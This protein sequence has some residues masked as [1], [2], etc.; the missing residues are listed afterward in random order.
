ML[1]RSGIT[2]SSHRWFE[3][4]ADWL[5]VRS[6]RVVAVG[7]V[8]VVC[9]GFGSIW[10][11][12]HLEPLGFFPKDNLVLRDVQRLQKDLT[13]TDTIEATVDFGRS[14]ELA[15]LPFVERLRYVR[16][17]E[18]K[19]AS[20]PGIVHTMS[21]ATLFPKEMPSGLELTQLLARAQKRQSD[22]DFLAGGDQYWRLSAYIRPDQRGQIG[23]AHV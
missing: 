20:H 21:L 11:R 8:V 12:S 3:P 13:T 16:D 14:L 4:L 10:L 18:H 2:D 15:S 19:I 6:R 17:L 1:F 22:N 23:R 9:F 5:L 7:A